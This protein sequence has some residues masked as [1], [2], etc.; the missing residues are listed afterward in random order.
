M[1]V[2]SEVDNPRETAA[3]VEAFL[4]Q[5]P[6]DLRLQKS[7]WDDLA[8]WG[9]LAFHSDCI[10]AA[11]TIYAYLVDHHE[12]GYFAKLRRADITRLSGDPTA[13]LRQLDSLK[14]EPGYDYRSEVVRALALMATKRYDQASACLEGIVIAQPDNLSYLRMLLTAYEQAGQ[15][16]RAFAV[17][18]V[19]D[20]LPVDARFE[21]RIRVRMA[22]GRY[23]DAW[24][25]LRSDLRRVPDLPDKMIAKIIRD[26]T[27]ASEFD[28]V[29]MIADAVGA[30][31]SPSPVVLA[32]L[33]TTYAKRRDWRNG[34]ALVASSSDVL[35]ETRHPALWIATIHFLCLNM[36]LAE[37]REMLTR[38]GPLAEVPPTASSIVGDLLA[39]TDEWAQLEALLEDRVTRKMPI[40]D[41]LF[42]DAVSRMARHTGHYRRVLDLLEASMVGLS[43]SPVVDCRDRL[44]LEVAL[45]GDLG[46]TV[47]PI[48]VSGRLDPSAWWRPILNGAASTPVGFGWHDGTA[49]AVD[50]GIYFCTDR[51][52]F[53]GTCVAV[54]SLLNENRE[55][56]TSWPLT[57]VCGDDVVELADSVLASM[58][59]ALEVEVR[60]IPARL[61][62]PA[63]DRFRTSWGVFSAS[64][65][66][67]DA[68]YFRIFT[69][70][71]LLEQGV[72]G[73]AL[74]LDSDTLPGP[75]ISRLLAFE[76]AGNPL[77]ARTEAPLTTIERAAD[78]LGITI[79]NY[80]NSGVLLFDL[81]HASLPAALR[82]SVAFA[83]EH[84]ELLTFVD[85]CALNVG[86]A[87]LRTRLPDECNHFTR[88]DELEVD[89]ERAPI[90]R[91]YLQ[92]PKPWDPA[93]RGVNGDTWRRGFADLLQV[94]S[95]DML[96]TLL[97]LPFRASTHT[98][99]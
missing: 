78:K 61:L 70:Q 62:I 75:S 50:G 21:L 82:R 63:M 88:S 46:M 76:L 47:E 38:W 1:A 8:R 56:R 39:S 84:P 94:L 13:A 26:F 40:D 68:A 89:A 99:S 95:P 11:A 54:W 86:F 42:L 24:G 33:L 36:Q 19:I 17:E 27:E 10:S 67:S 77:G 34:E 49:T 25:V 92:S 3:A 18:D 85:Q 97:A 64:K 37:A 20:T 7:D 52:Y 66:L 80:F 32:A 90:V 98:G 5:A 71:W 60:V 22:A 69:A 73:R 72:Q 81:E 96:R 44:L 31:T 45:L 30:S 28:R 91:H 15:I 57:V 79:G 55:L 87:G 65:G 43:P 9:D 53:V 58:A 51:N 59:G 16:E 12:G 6:S 35:W 2:H 74:Y 23:D 29:S 48:E 14:G 83:Q 41:R 93:Y 4:L